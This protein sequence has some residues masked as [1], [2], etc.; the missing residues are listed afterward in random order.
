MKGK[1]FFCTHKLAMRFPL[2]WDP[3]P[4]VQ[5]GNLKCKGC[6]LRGQGV[7]RTKKHQLP[8]IYNVDL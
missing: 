2:Q 1:R 8:L 4:P 7:Y 3:F 6:P 5:M